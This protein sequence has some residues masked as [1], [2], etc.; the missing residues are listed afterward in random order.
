[1]RQ[2]IDKVRFVRRD[3]DPLLSRF[4]SPI[5][6]DFDVVAQ[7]TNNIRYVEHFRRIVTRPDILFAAGDG[8]TTTPEVE[9]VDHFTT[10]SIPNFNQSLIPPNPIPPAGPGTIEG[11]AGGTLVLTFNKVGPTYLNSATGFLDENNSI[12]YYQWASFDGST[13]AP[14]LYPDVATL[15]ELEQQSLIQISPPVLPQVPSGRPT[16]TERQPSRAGK[17]RTRGHFLRFPVLCL[18]AWR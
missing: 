18:P 17:H 6:N 13:N 14:F 8:V 2:G 3:F 9:T 11:P 12:F 1:M 10:A 4:F 15:A 16:L 7:T 5:T